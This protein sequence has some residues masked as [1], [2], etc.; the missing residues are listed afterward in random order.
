M[1][2]HE[3]ILKRYFRLWLDKDTSSL[4]QIFA[5]NV[6]YYESWGPVY[7][8]LLQL[9]KWFE[10]WHKL[11]SVLA[12]DISEF[13]SNENTVVCQWY[14]Q[15]EYDGTIA[16]FD[17]VSWVLFGDDDKIVSIREYQSKL[18]HVYPYKAIKGE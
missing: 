3:Q 17:G 6:I 7:Q 5:E 11:G 4:K 16:G 10:D 1:D 18:P 2:K 13:L 14:F 8:G 12:W 15:C 9:E